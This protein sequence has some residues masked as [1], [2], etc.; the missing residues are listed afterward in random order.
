[1]RVRKRLEHC[2][3]GGTHARHLP[4][5]PLSAGLRARR[6]VEH[7]VVGH[8]RQQ[9]IEI[10]PVPCVGEA[11][12]QLQRLGVRARGVLVVVDGTSS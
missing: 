9:G 11:V 1:M 2:G 7:T 8:H 12:Q 6:C 5:P 4:P 3:A 10:V